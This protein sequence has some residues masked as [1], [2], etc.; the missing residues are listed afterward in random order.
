MIRIHRTACPACLT[1]SPREGDAYRKSQVVEALWN[2]QHGKCCYSEMPIPET[3]HGKAVEHIKPKATF[4]LLRNKWSN[5]LLVCPQCNG[6]KSNKFPEMLTENEDEPN[7]VCLRRPSGAKPAL[8][9]PSL[10]SDDPSDDPEYH[11]TYVL[12]NRD[13]L[14]GQIIPRNN[15]ARGRMTIK[16]TGIDDDV[17]VRERFDRLNETLEPE[18]RNLLRAKKNGDADALK[19]CLVTFSDYL[20]S[21]GKFAGLARAYAIYKKLDKHFAV[22]VPRAMPQRA[23]K[24]RRS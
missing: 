2:M 15:S 13:P 14:Y 22:Q 24:R 7:V 23:R 3:G 21:T 9:D 11:L 5:L 12:D 6:K 20:K 8:I 1:D 10:P 17:F 19:A 4:T 18:Y 16:V